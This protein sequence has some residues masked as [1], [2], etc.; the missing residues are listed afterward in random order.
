MSNDNFCILIF[1]GK[2]SIRFLNFLLICLPKLTGLETNMKGAHRLDPLCFSNNRCLFNTSLLYFS[3]SLNHSEAFFE[4][5]PSVQQVK[6]GIQTLCGAGGMR[7]V[8]HSPPGRKQKPKSL[9]CSFQMGLST[10]R[11]ATGK[12]WHSFLKYQLCFKF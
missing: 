11:K 1:P 3:K 8:V 10:L 9:A 2:M 12:I 4:L 6:M 7:N 5:L